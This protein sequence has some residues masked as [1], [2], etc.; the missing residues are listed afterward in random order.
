MYLP[1]NLAKILEKSGKPGLMEALKNAMS[2]SY[3]RG[4][5]LVSELGS[6][7]KGMGKAYGNAVKD[8]GP[9]LKG[10]RKFGSVGSAA[11]ALKD[12]IG[13]PTMAGLRSAGGSIKKAPVEAAILGAGGA[14]LLGG[15]G[16]GASKLRGS[17]EEKDERIKR[18]L[19][20][21]D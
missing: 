11:D 17:D 1:P 14:G 5:G 20:H 10:N 8:L 16:Y 6:A 9:V 18:L 15:A 13:S 7:G 4:K 3:G 19:R 12:A 21:R 2:E